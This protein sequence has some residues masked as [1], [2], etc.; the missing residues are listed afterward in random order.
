MTT[1]TQREL[2]GLFDYVGGR[3]NSQL[4][5]MPDAE[6]RWEPVPGCWS[7]RPGADGVFRAE[8]TFPPPEPA[9]FTTIAWRLWHIGNDC[10]QGYSDRMFEG[11]EPGDAH[12][13]PGTVAGGVE[14]LNREWARFREHVAATD[15]A[16]LALP[17]GPNAGPYADDTH[18]ALV[19]HALDEV[20]HHSAEIGVLRDLYR[21]RAPDGGLP[22]PA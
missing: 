6:Y 5:G 15:D 11:R 1:T 14:Q 9:P 17:L 20:I 3:L 13:W 7:V 4:K 19:L 22:A 2:L 16:A 21:H 8:K 10:L 12:A 18:H